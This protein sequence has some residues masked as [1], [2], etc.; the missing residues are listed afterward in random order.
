MSARMP[1]P[2]MT[3]RMNAAASSNG[4]EN[5]SIPAE[6][7][8]WLQRSYLGRRRAR[9]PRLS[10]ARARLR[11]AGFSFAVPRDP[12]AFSRDR[13]RY[14]VAAGSAE[15]RTGAQ[16]P[17]FGGLLRRRV[18]SPPKEHSKSPDCRQNDTG[19]DQP[20]RKLKLHQPI[21]HVRFGRSRRTFLKLLRP[22]HEPPLTPSLV[23][24]T[25]R[26]IGDLVD[27]IDR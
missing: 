12:E 8:T 3:P 2:A 17:L 25:G 23:L 11:R 16:L 5:H 10:A 7:G 24:W 6:C 1:Y 22:F 15:R 27:S 9:P 20:M 19:N 21:L 13:T 18:L 4:T 26:R 14:G